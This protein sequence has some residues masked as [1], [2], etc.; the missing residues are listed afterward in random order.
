VPA[1]TPEILTTF[2]SRPLGALAFVALLSAIGLDRL[3]RRFAVPSRVDAFMLTVVAALAWFGTAE[4]DTASAAYSYSVGG[5]VRVGRLGTFA[6]RDGSELGPILSVLD[7]NA[8][9]SSVVVSAPDVPDEYW[10]RARELGR[11]DSDVRPVRGDARFRIVAASRPGAAPSS[12]SNALA[13]ASHQGLAIWLL[14]ER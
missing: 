10:K 7:A 14:E 1:L 8:P 11:L 12:T 2:P 9:G 4:V 3:A 6:V 5:P 13:V